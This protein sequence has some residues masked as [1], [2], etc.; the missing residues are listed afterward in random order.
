[1]QKFDLHFCS[2]FEVENVHNSESLQITWVQC[3]HIPKPQ[4]AVWLQNIYIWQSTDY[5]RETILFHCTVTRIS[6]A[7]WIIY[8]IIATLSYIIVFLGKNKLCRLFRMKRNVW[9]IK[10]GPLNTL[11]Y[12]YATV[13]TKCF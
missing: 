5:K 11:G 2:C 12:Q 7:I 3:L 1:M 8:H 4:Y 9:I 13:F 10:I 6:K